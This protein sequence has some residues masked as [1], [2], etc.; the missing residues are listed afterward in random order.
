MDV[1]GERTITIE[2][3]AEDGTVLVDETRDLH[4]GGDV[5]FGRTRRVGSHELRITV[6]D[7]DAIEDETAETVRIDESRFS[8]LVLV[9]P[10]QIS[11]TRTVA[12]LGVCRRHCV[13]ETLRGGDVVWRSRPASIENLVR[14]EDPVARGVVSRAVTYP[15]R[16]SPPKPRGGWAR[17]ENYAGPIRESVAV[18]VQRI[19][20]LLQFGSVAVAVAVALLGSGRTDPSGDR[21]HSGE[22]DRDHC[23]R[24]AADVGE[25]THSYIELLI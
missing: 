6:A 21:D 10:D 25:G 20:T 3:V 24:S 4:P 14:L 1:D 8:V 5:E 9:E 18:E 19:G 15:R 22:E 12:D 13:A 2:V 11:V 23:R 16:L 7:G 17:F